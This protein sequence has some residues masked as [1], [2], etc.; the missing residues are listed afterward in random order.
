MCVCVYREREREIEKEK[1]KELELIII[2]RLFHYMITIFGGT[3]VP[4]VGFI[5]KIA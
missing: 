2:K 4:V 1:E 3:F 5:M